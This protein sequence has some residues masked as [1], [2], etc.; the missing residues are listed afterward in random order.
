MKNIKCLL[1]HIPRMMKLKDLEKDTYDSKKENITLYR[2][3]YC[4]KILYSKINYVNLDL[5]EPNED[6]EVDKETVEYFVKEYEGWSINNTNHDLFFSGKY[7]EGAINLVSN[8]EL[9]EVE[10]FGLIK[11]ISNN[12]GMCNGLD[13]KVNIF[14][15]K[16]IK[17]DDIIV[18]KYSPEYSIRTLEA[19]KK[20]SNYLNEENTLENAKTIISIH[21]NIVKRYNQ[22]KWWR[23]RNKRK[24]NIVSEII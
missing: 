2:C 17:K 12:F 1:G 19:S 4:K 5:E 14:E 23:L 24:C 6:K 13:F 8:S 3:K 9:N 10:R 16:Y 20:Y 15:S 7:N 22:S 18:P 11:I 21:Y